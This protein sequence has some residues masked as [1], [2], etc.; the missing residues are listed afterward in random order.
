[1]KGLSREGERGER[2]SRVVGYSS[3]SQKKLKNG[4]KKAVERE[5]ERPFSV[6]HI[7]RGWGERK[8]REGKEV[9]RGVRPH[10][11]LWRPLLPPPSS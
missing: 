9:A 1:M 6:Q 2:E 3:R 10:S 7:Q 4:G 5:R 8:D 11:S